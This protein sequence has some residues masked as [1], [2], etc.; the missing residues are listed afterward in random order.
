MKQK[1]GRC[2]DDRNFPH[3][4][5]PAFRIDSGIVLTQC[6]LPHELMAAHE[7]GAQSCR[8]SREARPSGHSQH[9][10]VLTQAEPV[11]RISPLL[12]FRR[13]RLLRSIRL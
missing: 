4:S 9:R 3:P 8:K 7:A 1:E 12:S 5:D 2:L 11:G 13:I 6:V 10:C